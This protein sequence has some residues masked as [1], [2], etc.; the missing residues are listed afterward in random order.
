MKDRRVAT[1]RNCPP[2]R[3]EGQEAREKSQ[4]WRR[5][6]WCRD[7]PNV[8]RPDY[9][10]REG[11][12]GQRR[13]AGRGISSPM[14]APRPHEI[15]A[16]IIPAARSAPSHPWPPGGPDCLH[17][18]IELPVRPPRAFART[19]SMGMAGGSWRR[20]RE[21]LAGGSVESALEARGRQNY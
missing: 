10:Q 19:P 12:G 13:L 16:W 14:E 5:P 17:E 11:A 8:R 1:G 9:R 6:R 21:A 7:N 18:H 20:R 4:K 2:L 3:K 15:E